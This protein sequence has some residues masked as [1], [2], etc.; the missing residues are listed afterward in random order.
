MST[1]ISCTVSLD[2]LFSLRYVRCGGTKCIR[3]NVLLSVNRASGCRMRE[4]PLVAPFCDSK[5]MGQH[6]RESEQPRVANAQVETP[7]TCERRTRAEI[8]NQL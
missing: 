5:V 6:S 7:G 8:R 4:G 2:G 1:C 3:P